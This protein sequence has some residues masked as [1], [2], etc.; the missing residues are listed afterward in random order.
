[1]HGDT[2]DRILAN[3]HRERPDLDVAPMALYGRLARLADVLARE[4]EP[5]YAQFG[6]GGGKFD[7]LATLRRSG[8]PYRQTPTALSRSLLLSSGGMTHRLDHLESAGLI[9]R[10]P[11]PADRRGSLVQLTDLGREA[12]DRALEAHVVNLHR[13]FDTAVPPEDRELLA[14]LLRALLVSLEPGEAAIPRA[15]GDGRSVEATAE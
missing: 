8:A 3:W 11:D 5:V 4:F 14:G 6:L 7:V 1:M 9:V 10:L 2:V 13:V 15:Q 12:I